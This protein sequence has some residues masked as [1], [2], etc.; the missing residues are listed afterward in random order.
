VGSRVL[1]L[2][3]SSLVQPV[4]Y[5]LAPFSSELL[6]GA[7]ADVQRREVTIKTPQD[8]NEPMNSILI[9]PGMR[10]PVVLACLVLLVATGRSPAEPVPEVQQQVFSMARTWPSEE[11]ADCPFERSKDI[12]GI[13]I[14]SRYKYYTGAD[15]WYPS[16][17]ADGNLYS[18][19]TDGG[20]GPLD[21]YGGGTSWSGYPKATTCHAKI[22]GDDPMDLKVYHLGRHRAL[23]LPF[24]GRYPCG[25]LVYEG[26]WYYGTYCLDGG[27]YAWWHLRPFVGFRWSDDLG[28]TWTDAPCTPQNNLFQEPGE[29][30]VKIGA[31]HFVD[32]GRNM[33]HS[34]DGKAYLL[35]H[36]ATLEKGTLSWNA[37]DQVY[38][39]RVTPSPEVINNRTAYEFF[40]GYDK[41]ENPVWTKDFGQ[42]KPLIDWP[43]KAG[44]VTMTYNAPLKKYIMLVTD[45]GWTGEDKFHT[46]ALESDHVTG[47]WK[48]V[49]YMKEFGTQA[50]FVNM[51]SKFISPDGKTAWLWYSNNCI[52]RDSGDPTGGMYALSQCEIRFFTSGDVMYPLGDPLRVPGNVARIAKFSCS[53]VSPALTTRQKR[54][55]HGEG[56]VNGYVSHFEYDVWL[57]DNES[58][59]AWLRL[60]WN[61]PQTVDR[62]AL[63]AYPAANHYVK[64]GTLSFSDGSTV[65]LTEPLPDDGSSGIEIRFPRRTITWLKFEITE[66][67]G[68]ASVAEIAVFKAP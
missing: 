5:G 24:G 2:P 44:I 45:G 41:N 38:L 21:G 12:V 47:P 15:T 36:G 29:G 25:S 42:I 22:T 17:A 16:W 50:Y 1:R 63:F 20:V 7:T 32:F 57:S 62:V 54:P 55:T 8:T 28:K 30:K 27:R 9:L 64:S 23:P 67:Q 61:G 35:A 4:C 59:G 66:M 33:E 43:Q 6:A 14:T 49:T 3:R 65:K 46:Y 48:L 13:G 31:P 51:P 37:G 60:D 53:S 58:A 39:F 56:A 10:P 68:L 19:W 40:A 18:P 52:S 34:P 11:P 26:I